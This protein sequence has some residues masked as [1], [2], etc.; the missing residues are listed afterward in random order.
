MPT[1]STFRETRS[2]GGW[3][4]A[5][6][7]F[8]LALAVFVILELSIVPSST[9]PMV[10]GFLL[11]VV[12]LLGLINAVRGLTYP[13]SLGIG[14]SLPI[15]W[16]LVLSGK[17]LGGTIETGPLTLFGLVIAFATVGVIIALSGFVV[18]YLG[19]R[20]IAKYN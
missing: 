4:L 10:L 5:A 12:A 11:V 7:F 14:V 20:T 2:D 13:S 17:L 1:H 3:K 18:G 15:A 16:L 19:R 8:I 6:G 9:E